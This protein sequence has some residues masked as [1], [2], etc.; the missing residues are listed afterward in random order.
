MTAPD[1]RTVLATLGYP[2]AETVTPVSGGR[3]TAIFR[4]E[5]G[6]AAYALRVFR[7][8]QR[9]VSQAEVLARMHVVA[10]P[11]EYWDRSWL[12][13]GGL[14]PDDL[15]CHSGRVTRNACSASEYPTERSSNRKT[16]HGYWLAETVPDVP[17]LERDRPRSYGCDLDQDD[18]AGEDNAA[19]VG[20]GRV[21]QQV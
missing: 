6:M 18:V 2:G 16:G 11:A 4:V 13:W 3:D 5:H 12:R 7:P 1:P 8:E 9:M 14:A 20:V 19:I 21:D 10:V 15:P 17:L